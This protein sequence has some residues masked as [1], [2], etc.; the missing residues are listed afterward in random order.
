MG[1]ER[2]SNIY[3]RRCVIDAI[4]VCAVRAQ[5]NVCL[6]SA[7]AMFVEF[8]MRALIVATHIKHKQM[9]GNQNAVKAI[10][11]IRQRHQCCGTVTR[12]V[13]Q[14]KI[15]VSI[16]T[17]WL[18]LRIGGVLRRLPTEK[19]T[20]MKFTSALN[21]CIEKEIPNYKNR[22]WDDKIQV[23]TAMGHTRCGNQFRIG[24]FLFILF[25]WFN[26]S[27]CIRSEWTLSTM[28]RRGNCIVCFN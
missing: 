18:R 3:V 25:F 14:R 9:N 17:S 1:H 11:Q 22:E 15:N 13:R 24:F 23:I 10:L 21:C 2:Q 19:F 12:S 28:H 27:H 26:M 8:Q 5:S 4:S 20:S 7:C 6:S 16:S